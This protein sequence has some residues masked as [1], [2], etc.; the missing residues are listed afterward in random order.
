MEVRSAV[1]E[2]TA[3]IVV[4]LV[5]LLAIDVTA[6][7]VRSEI[8]LQGTGF[9]TKDST[10]QGTLQRSTNTGGFLV[11]YRY[12]FN[13]WLSAE[14]IRDQKFITNAAGAFHD[15][16]VRTLK[17]VAYSLQTVGSLLWRSFA[18]SEAR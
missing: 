15:E 6:Q 17:R 18:D 7:E 3:I 10:D 9:F 16:L 12:H 1:I 14:H 11:G 4:S 8:S 13:R 2:R 5:L